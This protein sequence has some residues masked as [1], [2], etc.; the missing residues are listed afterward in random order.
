MLLVAE[1]TS[2]P[3]RPARSVLVHCDCC[4]M[5]WGGKDKPVSQID[6]LREQ[7]ARAQ[8]LAEQSSLPNVRARFTESAEA[9]TRLIVRAERLEHAQGAAQEG[10][11]RPPRL[12]QRPRRRLG[13]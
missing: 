9:W 12:L 2:A 1:K 8:S 3:E 11:G 13:S 4:I 7:A 10:I 5:F 6:Y